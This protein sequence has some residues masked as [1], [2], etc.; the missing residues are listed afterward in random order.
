MS[1]VLAIAARELVE[2]GRSKAFIVSNVVIVLAIG[3]GAL[4]PSVLPGGS[5]AKIAVFDDASR[6]VVTLAGERDTFLGAGVQAIEVEDLDAAEAVVLSG[7]ADAA[8][9]DGTTVL[10]EQEPPAHVMSALQAPAHSLALDRSMSEAGLS[11]V[12]RREILS[13]EALTVESLGAGGDDGVAEE[14]FIVAIVGVMALYGLL[15][16]YGQWVAQGIVEEKQSRVIEVLLSAVTP[17]QLLGGKILGIGLLGFAQIALIAGLGA[18]AAVYATGADVPAGAFGVIGLVLAWYVLG[19]AL[20]ATLFAAIG[21][22]CARMEDLQSAAMPV[23]V[24]IFGGIFAVQVAAVAPEGVVARVTGLLP[25]TAPLVQP[26]R[27]ATGAAGTLEVA[28]AVLLG[29]ATIAALIPLTTRL[30]SGGV[31]RT[32]SRISFRDA[33]RAGT[34]G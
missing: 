12:E 13:S 18:G 30:Y 11:Q 7:E 21:A 20:Y 33:W 2:R 1:I 4:L 26:I 6:M 19:Y 10:A 16:F 14:L 24:L 34:G 9:V 8:L 29:I 22:I 5:P 25:F 3:L 23:F 32:G 28:G 31:L 15:V 27:V 17:L